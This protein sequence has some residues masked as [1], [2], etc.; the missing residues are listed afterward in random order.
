MLAPEV[1]SNHLCAGE[2]TDGSSAKQSG[3]TRSAEAPDRFGGDQPPGRSLL[4]EAVWNATNG[5]Q[6]LRGPPA[7]RTNP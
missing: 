3:G 6:R 1:Q 2:G 4:T 7:P 5:H